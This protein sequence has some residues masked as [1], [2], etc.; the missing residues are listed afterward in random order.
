MTMVSAAYGPS[1]A[2]QA[3]LASSTATTDAGNAPLLP[4]PSAGLGGDSVASLAALIMQADQQDRT[5]ARTL[6]STEDDAALQD[7]N[8]QVAALRQKAD[9]DRDSALANG[10]GEAAS[11]ALTMGSACFAPPSPTSTGFNWNTGLQ[12]AAKA[13]EGVGAIVS[14]VKKGDAE[15]SDATAAQ[16]AAAS[17]ADARAYDA[18]RSDA[19]DANDSMQKVE[20]FLQQHQQT[21]NASK[22]TAASYR[23]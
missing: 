10:I 11:G 22:L 7:S 8:R 13:A 9:D 21:E 19:Q 15:Q 6:E 17:Q 23:A 18:A 14:A 4:E 2:S 16:Y 5:Q 12:G 3:T 20:Q 1:A